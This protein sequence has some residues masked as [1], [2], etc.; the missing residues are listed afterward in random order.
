MDNSSGCLAAPVKRVLVSYRDDLTLA[1][2]YAQNPMAA[3]WRDESRTICERGEEAVASLEVLKGLLR[4]G[5]LTC[6]L[7]ECHR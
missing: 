7:K 6:S 5:P 1:G 4:L 3:F 2:V